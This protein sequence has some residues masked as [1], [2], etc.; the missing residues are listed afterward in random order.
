[1]FI[2]FPPKIPYN[3]KHMSGKDDKMLEL[4]DIRK[5][6]TSGDMNVMALD[7][8]SL[9]FR[10]KE[11]VSI[12]GPSGSGKT[13]LLNI[14]GGL[15]QYTSG[16]LV[17]GGR[18]TKE[19]KDRDWDSYRNHRIGFVFQSYNLIPHQTVLAN[20][21]LALTLSGVGKAERRKRAAEALTRV[22]LADQLNKRPSQM[23]GGQMQRVAIARALVNN[24]DILLA[25][26]PTGALDT[27]TSVQIMDLLREISSDKLIIMVT[28]NPE[29]AEKYSSRI[30][31]MQ[32]GKLL[33][34]SAPYTPEKTILPAA[35]AK[36]EKTSMSFG[37]A[38]SLSL[39]NLMTKKGRTLLTSFAGSIGIIGIA[40]ILSL[41]SGVQN[42]IN[43][44]QEDTL[45]SYP[46]SIEAR[47]VDL[48]S[49][50]SSA[51][52]MQ[53]ESD[54]PLDKVYSSNIMGDMTSL[55]Q[56]QVQTNN[57]TAFKDYI[58]ENKDSFLEYANEITYN[59]GVTPQ[60][61]TTLDDGSVQQVNP[62]PVLDEMGMSQIMS[63]NPMMSAYS[64]NYNV[65]TELRENTTLRDASY[66]LVS[67]SWPENY[68]EIVLIVDPNNEVSDYTL[69]TLGMKDLSEID[70]ML[71]A[72]ESKDF[73]TE[74]LTFDYDELIGK[75]F[76]LVAASDLYEDED[77]DGVW[78]DRSGDIDFLKTTVENG[79]ALTITGIVRETDR[80]SSVPGGIGYTHALT[81]YLIDRANDSAIVA[82]QKADPETDVLTGKPFD[83]SEE[84]PAAEEETPAADAPAA[85]LTD[86]QKSQLSPM[87][88]SMG[89]D[90]ATMTDDEWMQV[91]AAAQ[92]LSSAGSAPEES[93][94]SEQDSLSVLTEMGID[95]STLSDEQLSYLSTMSADQIREMMASYAAPTDNTYDGNLEA[96]GAADYD[97]PASIELIPKSFADKEELTALISDY[98]DACTAD[99]REEDTIDYTDMVGLLMSSVTTIINAISYVLIAFVGISLV[100]SSI[101]IGIITYI[102][103]LERTK[104]IGILRAIGASKHDVSNVFNAE[105]LIIGFGAGAL[106]I[107]VTL[108]LLI[109]ANLIIENLTGIAGLAALPPAAAVILV[110]ISM[111]LTFISGLIPSGMAAR[112]DPVESLRSE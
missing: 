4:K 11:F 23:S 88:E 75:T 21:E 35:T 70:Q 90:P 29:L 104:E 42:Y 22:G 61:Y 34:D 60:V 71:N 58:E 30:V 28:H 108:L 96:F 87:A 103:V 95:P 16:D 7:G 14:I 105:T 36:K 97:S 53:A 45:A 112:K 1:M 8:V 69:Y 15:D 46:V 2:V 109:P 32:D 6:Y 68:D 50:L 106:G 55:M 76:S 40:L 100:V 64:S 84:Q 85:M 66:E 63:A 25:D 12:L 13:T 65:F 111:L 33:S 57:L 101:M 54:H 20:V 91:A 44:V 89:M 86:D 52:Q 59:Y 51:A 77:G 17:I 73:T 9:S 10:E 19:F 37:T 43:G 102:S 31:R 24:P 5:S 83:A 41:S 49:M 3:K 80:Q 79:T 72:S 47:T 56:T 26:E 94:S 27:K 82:A 92:S 67:G 99:G 98:N 93:A 81:E 38:L 39:N 74:D 110:A 18:S 78:V 107:I 48:T 62:S